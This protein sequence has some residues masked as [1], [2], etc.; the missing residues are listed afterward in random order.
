M[1]T[2]EILNRRA[3]YDFEIIETHEAGI[4]LKGTEVKSLRQGKAALSG[5]FAR[6][7][8]GEVWL[9]GANIQEYTQGNR[10]NHDPLRFRKLLL[11]RSEIHKLHQHSAVKGLSLVPLK[12]YFNDRG[13]AKILIGVGKSKG[14]VD[15]RED[16]KKRDTD[17]QI[18][19]AM[20]RRR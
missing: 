7:D 11:K 6:V 15:R 18:R 16:I 14:E 19:Q 9:I 13:F 4:V 12:L 2:K 20:G 3:R 5:S 1:D 10:F 8:K 17:R